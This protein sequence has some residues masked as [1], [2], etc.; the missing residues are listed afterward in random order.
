MV[1]STLI[2]EWSRIFFML[3]IYTKSLLVEYC[4]YW[5]L[6]LYSF[7]H[8]TK[9]MKMKKYDHKNPE[10]FQYFHDN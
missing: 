3:T 6:V 9:T 1:L 4:H 8:Y 2:K 5:L 10:P 7:K